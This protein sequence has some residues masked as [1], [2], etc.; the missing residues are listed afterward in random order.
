MPVYV[1]AENPFDYQNPTHIRRVLSEVTDPDEWRDL[2]R[3]GEWEIIESGSMQDAIQSAGFDGFY[4]KEHGRRNLAVYE[5]NQLK[6]ATGNQGSFSE[7][8]PDLRL[9]LR[10]T[11]QPPESKE[12]KQWFGNSY[13]TSGGEPL[14]MY[15]GTARDITIFKGKQAKAIFVTTEP[16]VAETYADMGVDYMRTEAYKA[17]TRDE[18]VELITVVADRAMMDGTITK[19]ELKEIQSNLKRRGPPL[20]SEKKKIIDLPYQIEGEII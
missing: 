13:F 2:L 3:T 5:P 15:H 10:S 8:S 1:K 18:K 11:R 12:F 9:S 17:L 20:N 6:S 19:A 4:V 7:E 14:I 16:K